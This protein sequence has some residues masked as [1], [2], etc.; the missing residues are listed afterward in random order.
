MPV[1]GDQVVVINTEEEGVEVRS[2][3]SGTKVIR[4]ADQEGVIAFKGKVG[5]APQSAEPKK[6][7]VF[8]VDDTTPN[9]PDQASKE[10]V[11]RALSK[12]PLEPQEAKVVRKMGRI[13]VDEVDGVTLKTSVGSGDQAMDAKVTVGSGST[14]V[15]D[16]AGVHTAEQA[17]EAG[18]RVAATIRPMADEPGKPAQSSVQAPTSN[19]LSM[20]PADWATLHWRS[21]ERFI[22]QQ[23][24]IGLI[25][26]ILSVEEIKTIQRI[27]KA[28]LQALKAVQD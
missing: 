13:T 23:K 18:V 6:K 27:C 19:Y 9:I 2:T 28:R 26:Y 15:V 5:S 4:G 17:E 7:N 10:E 3:K 24:D 20:L 12:Q 8:T 14:D 22:N 25:E 21:K 1:T 11:E 16:L